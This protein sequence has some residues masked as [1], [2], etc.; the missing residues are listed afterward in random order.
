MSPPHLRVWWSLG[1]NDIVVN[2]PYELHFPSATLRY[3]FGLDPKRHPKSYALSFSR[4]ANDLDRFRI[5][6]ALTVQ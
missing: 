2:L 6:L 5:M 1:A 4:L 3:L